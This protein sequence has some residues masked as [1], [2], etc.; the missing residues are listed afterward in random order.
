MR[1][2]L[3]GV[4]GMGVQAAVRRR[5]RG[6]VGI[7]GVGV[8]QG[9]RGCWG[10][11]AP[12]GRGSRWVGGAGLVGFR[13]GGEAESL[14]QNVM[15][16]NFNGKG[17]IFTE[18]EFG[19]I[20]RLNMDASFDALPPS[21]S[22]W[23][24]NKYFGASNKVENADLLTVFNSLRSKDLEE[25]DDMVKLYL[26]YFLKC[27]ILGKESQSTIKLDY[28]SMVEDLEYFNQY[29][30][31]LDSYNAIMVSLHKV[32]SLRNGELN[33]SST[34]SLCGFPLAFQVWG[35]ETIPLLRQLY[36]RKMD[37][38][39]PRI[40]NWE[41]SNA[42]T[43]GD[44]RKSIF[45]NNKELHVI[46]KLRLI[47][48]EEE[49][50]YSLNN[51]IPIPPIKKKKR[52]KEKVDQVQ[53]QYTYYGQEATPVIDDGHKSFIDDGHTS[54]THNF[55][56]LK[57]HIHSMDM[58]IDRFLHDFTNLYNDFNEFK[59]ESI[60]EFKSLNETIRNMFDFVRKGHYH[61]DHEGNV[62]DATNLQ[63]DADD[64]NPHHQ[65]SVN[66]SDS[67]V[68]FVTPSKVP[69]CDPRL[70]KHSDKMKSPFIVTTGTQE[71]LKNT[72]PPPDKF[73]PKRTIPTEIT[74]KIFN[75]MT[76]G[77]DVYIDYGICEIKK[78]FFQTLITEAGW[79]ADEVK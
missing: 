20:T 30:W 12:G 65:F 52:A 51:E 19:V 5:P 44:V 35:Y 54:S 28:F 64:E 42:Y 39:F 55:E 14:C 29:P 31:G 53:K 11:A 13:G 70:K 9:G 75:Y 22:N 66:E 8:D 69:Y 61:S 27:G 4:R 25:E 72:L 59:A 56:E 41:S 38:A 48:V 18:K 17:A 40:C 43:L 71:E 2:R 21:T 45:D 68:Q 34:Y 62:L 76:E 32:L 67:E 16:F 36:A 73:D 50:I 23:I 1:V 6:S 58:K 7:R 10:F 63:V 79:L 46:G 74:S 57:E 60:H 77:E 3:V 24:R 78:E 47:N 49:Y 33:P 37:D 26:L 15:E